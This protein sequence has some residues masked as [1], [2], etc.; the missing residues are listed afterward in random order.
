MRPRRAGNIWIRMS[1]RRITNAIAREERAAARAEQS[2]LRK[3]RGLKKVK[4]GA[5]KTKLRI[6]IVL[7]GDG[8]AFEQ[9][10]ISMEEFQRRAARAGH[11]LR[12][13]NEALAKIG[14][15]IGDGQRDARGEKPPTVT[16]TSQGGAPKPKKKIVRFW[17]APPEEF[18][19]R[20]R[21]ELG[22]NYDSESI[23]WC[24]DVD[25]VK[26]ESFIRRQGY[27]GLVRFFNGAAGRP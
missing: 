8:I 4:V 7:G 27:W 15:R 20:L 26:V 16:P 17:V 18:R 12:E 5:E 24:G 1:N 13:V 10:R 3:E 19:R 6:K 2:V 23:Y 14:L 21:P 25:P 22:L 9:G 11:E